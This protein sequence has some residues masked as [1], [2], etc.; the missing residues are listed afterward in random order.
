MQRQTS[1]NYNSASASE[2]TDLEEAQQTAALGGNNSDVKSSMWKRS[3]TWMTVVVIGAALL[4][5][6]PG[7][8][9]GFTTGQVQWGI[10]LSGAHAT[11]V[12][13]L[14]GLYYHYSQKI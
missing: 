6:V 7:L 4:I 9:L 10:A 12:G 5:M 8:V 11:V 2:G 1:N 13:I 14:A 3:S